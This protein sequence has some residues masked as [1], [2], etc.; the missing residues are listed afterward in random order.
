MFHVKHFEVGKH[1]ISLNKK[2]TLHGFIKNVSRETFWGWEVHN[3]VE[4]KNNFAWIY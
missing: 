4:Q 3:I 2:T 1:I